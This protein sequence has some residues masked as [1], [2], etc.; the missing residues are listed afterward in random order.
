MKYLQ[1][2]GA[3]DIINRA[4]VNHVN[5]NFGKGHRTAGPNIGQSIMDPSQANRLLT[6]WIYVYFEF[7]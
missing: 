6:R 7:W 5:L 2:R 4:E 3:T 1:I